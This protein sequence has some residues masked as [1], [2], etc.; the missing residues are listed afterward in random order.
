M[1]VSG[2]RQSDSIIHLSLSPYIYIYTRIYIF[3]FFSIL[4]IIFHYGLSPDIECSS[5]CCTVGLCCLSLL[6]KVVCVCQMSFSIS[7]SL[8]GANSSSLLTNHDVSRGHGVSWGEGSR[9]APGVEGGRKWK[10]SGSLA[11]GMPLLW[12]LLAP[13]AVPVILYQSRTNCSC[14]LVSQ[15]FLCL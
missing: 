4:C 7:S 6:Y 11:S 2:V 8:N 9:E 10:P 1:L 12:A 5:L 13:R 3:R 14:L 15:S